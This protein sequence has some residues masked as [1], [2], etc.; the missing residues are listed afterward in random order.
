[1]VYDFLDRTHAGWENNDG[2]DGEF[3]FDVASRTVTL[4]YNERYTASNNFN[5]EF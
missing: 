5:Y 2:A 3:V 1:M 4:D